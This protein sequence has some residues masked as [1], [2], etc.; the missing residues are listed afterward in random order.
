MGITTNP[1]TEAKDEHQSPETSGAFDVLRLPPFAWFLS[2]T[3][4]SNAAQWIQNVTLSWLVYDLTSSGALL[5][6]LNLVRSIATLGLAPAAGVVI[7]RISHR[8]LLYAVSIWLFSISFGFGL[9]L[10]GNP[11]VV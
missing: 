3:T 11:A 7:D 1:E 6:T 9:V 5:G 10:L 4:L 2:G 8:R